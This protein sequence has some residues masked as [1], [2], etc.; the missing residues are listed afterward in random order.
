MIKQVYY[1]YLKACLE[2]IKPKAVITFI[3][4]SSVFG[5]LAKHC[6]NFPFIAIQNGSR[7]SYFALPDSNYYVPHYFCFGT[8]EQELFPKLGYRVDHYYPVGSLVASLHFL[9]REQVEEKY[10]L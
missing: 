8:H 7:L 10:D 6:D 2:S 1:I 3:D 4:T 9:P 5:L